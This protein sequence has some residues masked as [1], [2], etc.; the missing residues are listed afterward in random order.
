M[1]FDPLELPRIAGWRA[2][3]GDD[4]FGVLDYLG[5]Q[6][7]ATLAVAFTE[8]FWP[9]FVEHRGCILLA[10]HFD[11]RGFEQWWTRLDGDCGAIE[12]TV[13]HL[14]LWDVFDP[15]A[16]DVPAQ[17]MRHLADVLAKTWRAALHEQF[18]DREVVV[19]VSDTPEDYGPT[20][21]VHR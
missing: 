19:E 6:G 15:E 7:G 13:N 4:E 21:L 9:R 20:I 2:A 11:E 18:P 10:H 5:Q 12:A 14:H 16:E 8:L 1:S 17:A 3:I